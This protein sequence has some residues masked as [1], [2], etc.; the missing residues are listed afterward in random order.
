MPSQRADW[1]PMEVAGRQ[2]NDYGLA[3]AIR[4]HRIE[5]RRGFDES[6]LKRLVDM[7]ER[8]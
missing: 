6:T 7:V 2:E 8:G 1:L 3:S 5:V 4:G